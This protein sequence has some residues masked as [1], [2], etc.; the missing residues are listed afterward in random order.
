MQEQES[1]ALRAGRAK[2]KAQDW[3][4]AIESFETAL[5]EDPEDARAWYLLGFA[6]HGSGDFELALEVHARAAEFEAVRANVS[7]E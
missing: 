3:A 5:A 7:G 4:G 6:I 1:E 2:L